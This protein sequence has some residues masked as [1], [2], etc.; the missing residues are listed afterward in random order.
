MGAF[1]KFFPLILE[2][3]IAVERLI[4]RSKG[5][6]KKKLVLDAIQTGVDIAKDVDNKTVQT[7]SEMI[8]NTVKTLNDAGV[9][10]TAR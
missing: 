10:E 7:V 1:I 9:F 4:G 2:S 8:D 6:T 3:I 5:Q